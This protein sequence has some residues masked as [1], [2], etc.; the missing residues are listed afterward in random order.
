[1]CASYNDDSDKYQLDS[2]R[3]R[4]RVCIFNNK[5]FVYNRG[6]VRNGSEKDVSSL[7]NL[8]MNLNFD[9]DCFTDKTAKQM[10]QHINEI[11]KYDYTNV[12]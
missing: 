8:F 5:H 12:G 3:Y 6:N 10:R 4:G 11:S 1:M 7:N 2:F 9:V